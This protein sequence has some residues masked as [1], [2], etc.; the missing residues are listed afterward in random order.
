M[1]SVVAV[2]GVLEA[3]RKRQMSSLLTPKRRESLSPRSFPC[4]STSSEGTDKGSGM[5]I[6]VP[7]LPLLAAR[8]QSGWRGHAPVEGVLGASRKKAHEPIADPKGRACLSLGCFPAN[9]VLLRGRY[10]GR[11]G[12]G[13]SPSRTLR[14]GGGAD[15][16]G[17][18]VPPL[19]QYF[20]R[21]GEK[22]RRADSAGASP[23]LRLF[24]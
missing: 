15:Q 23:C 9:G 13:L 16:T 24:A 18:A 1:P 22:G 7:S 12:S 19:G 3:A 10:G 21:C 2:L 5:G 6:S 4:K 17:E 8:R 14:R 20:T 11:R